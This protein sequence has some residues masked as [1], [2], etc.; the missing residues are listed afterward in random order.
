MNQHPELRKHM[1]RRRRLLS[2]AERLECADR[3]AHH[4]A[5]T[6][7]FRCSRHI[8]CYWPVDGELDPLPLMQRAWARNKICYL[9]VLN[10]LP[11]QRLWFAPYREGDA[12][13]YNRYGILEPCLPVSEM[14][15][16]RSLDVIMAPLVAFD[17]QGNRLGMGGGFYDRTFAFLNY[18]Q[19]WRSPRLIGLAYDFQ[20]VAPIKREPWD[21]PLQGVL[22]EAGLYSSR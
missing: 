7:L 6:R 18:R 2:H 8:A 9:P 1:R 17:E 4:F 19:H 13:V 11:S 22:T 16:A 21:V 5:T 3:A 15:G 20:K 12:L 10:Q 14:A